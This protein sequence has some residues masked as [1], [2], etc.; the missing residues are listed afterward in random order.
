[1]NRQTFV[2][3]SGA[4]LTMRKQLAKTLNFHCQEDSR[5]GMTLELGAAER[6]RIVVERR[7]LGCRWCFPSTI[8]VFLVFYTPMFPDFMQ[9]PP[10]FFWI[11]D[12]IV[13]VKTTMSRTC[14]KGCEVSGIIFSE[15]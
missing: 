8:S 5:L 12:G 1:M 6:V 9:L 11:D 14:K 3:R 13:S 7:P 4:P 2:Q 10:F 15:I